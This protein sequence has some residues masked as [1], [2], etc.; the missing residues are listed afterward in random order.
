VKAIVAVGS[1]R[2]CFVKEG[3]EVHE[4]KVVPGA[5]NPSA[6]EIKEGLKEG[7]VILADPPGV[8]D[9]R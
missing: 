9:R 5:S 4:R 7:D 1:D 2:V 6:V 3:K 8:L